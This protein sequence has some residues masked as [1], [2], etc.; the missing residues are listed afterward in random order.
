[1][2][3]HTWQRALLLAISAL[4]GLALI[5][6]TILASAGWVHKPFPGFF[7]HE[8]LTVGPYFLSHWS[9]AT[10][11]LESLDRILTVDGK[12]LRRRG[13]LRELVSRSASGSLFRYRVL[14]NGSILDLAIPSMRFS[15]SDWLLS[16]GVYAIMGVAFLIVGITPYFLR[17]PAPAALP[18]AV[19][20][21]TLFAWLE[22]TFDFMTGGLLPKELRI[23]GL[24][25]TPSAAVHLALSLKAS[26][27][28]RRSKRIVLGG[29]YGGSLL[30]GWLSSA[31]F[32]GPPETWIRVFQIAY[33]YTAI[34][35]LSFLTI[36]ASA[37]RNT[38]VNLERSRL[39]VVF[40]GGAVGLLLPAVTTVLTSS[41]HWP[42]PYNLAVIPGIF[43]PLSVAYALLKY[44]LFDLGN[45]FRI[46]LSRITL[47]A[48]LL[49][50]YGAV[51]FLA[52]QWFGSYESDPLVPLLFSVLVAALFNPLLRGIEKAL[53][54][55]I[56][57]QEY[58]P[59][60]VEK[61]I[62]LY[63]RSLADAPRVAN[64]FVQRVTERI[65]IETAM[66][67][68]RPQGAREYLVA[69]TGDLK[70]QIDD[71]ALQVEAL[72]EKHIGAYR[73][74]LSRDEVMSD[75]SFRARREGWLQIFDQLDAELLMPLVFEHKFHGFV[76]F[77][78]KCSRSEYS[79]EDL[80]LLGTL[81]DQLAL[82]LENG[83]LYQE[84]LAARKHAEA[85]SERLIEAD[86]V[87]KQFVANICH[88]LRT[89]VSTIMGFSEILLDSGVTANARAILER[90]VHNGRELAALMDNLLDF[91]RMESG[92]VNVTLEIVRLREI[93]SAVEAMIQKM[94][95]RRPIE[96]WA[97]SDG[98]VEVI[99]T[100]GQKLQQI[101]VQLVTNALK[102][103]EK[104]KIE[105]S[106]RASKDDGR[107]VV[108]IAVADT[109]IGI[110]KED[111]EAIFE[112]FRQLDGSSTR[113]YGGTGLGLGLCKKLAEALG[114]RIKV[115]SEPGTGSVF[116]LLLP[117]RGGPSTSGRLDDSVAA[118]M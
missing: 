79:A 101:L 97:K 71:L 27:P 47:A 1:M 22:S 58:D 11:G 51:L 25:L 33:V 109:G 46:T 19:M 59:V 62:S 49:A 48:F 67:A 69:A 93:L 107:D 39:R 40:V 32:F 103:T 92:S 21:L 100:D 78:V 61:E 56:Y 60:L 16:F 24:T 44:S 113:Q 23:L 96:F 70:Q 72:S 94:I 75:P 53:D 20:G 7:V 84:S 86:R 2:A 3:R 29:L 116:S 99:E 15:L 111:Q 57:R 114:G 81:S 77:G 30:L 115:A 43:F 110:K 90:L 108:E 45:A 88:E 55:Y 36:I 117:L 76:T 5:G 17:A 66:L 74:G 9:G 63:L 41:F 54:R 73:H 14:R 83:R 34:G 42:I 104:G 82:S 87:K 89:P 28:L 26:G 105:L 13:E 85:A 4:L 91:S 6:A 118:A 37:L 112:D 50:I 52:R 80:R 106:L 38:A 98:I 95:R 12:P 102:F 35:A 68:Y 10:A 65:G 18:L 8:N 64:G 31:T